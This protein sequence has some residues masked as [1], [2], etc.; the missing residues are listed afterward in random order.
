MECIIRSRVILNCVGSATM[1]FTP[2]LR[3]A[4]SCGTADVP[5]RPSGNDG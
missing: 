2:F 3:K 1:T 5:R 4:E